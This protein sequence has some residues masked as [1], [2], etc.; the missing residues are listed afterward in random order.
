MK[1]N[2][3]LLFV[4]TTMFSLTSIAQYNHDN[5]KIKANSNS[6]AGN[7]PDNFDVGYKYKNLQLFPVVANKTFVDYNKDLGKF[8]LLKEAITGGKI[9]ITET[10]AGQSNQSG[11]NQNNVNIQQSNSLNLG[12]DVSGTV[13]TLIAKNVSSD[14]IFI[15]AGEVVKG[16]KQDRVIGQDVVIAPGQEVNLSAFCVENNRWQTVDGNNGQ[17]NGY[18]NVSSMDIRKIVTEDKNQSEVWQKVDEHTSKNGASSSTKTYTNLANSEEY[19]KELNAYLEKFKSSFEND[20]SV[21]GVIA[22]SGDKVIGCDLFATNQLFKDAYST[23]VYSYIGHAITNGSPVT[24]TNEMVYT[25]LDEILK[26]EEN[27]IENVEKNG[28]IYEYKK[29]KLHMTKY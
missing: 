13:N 23:L 15:M 29:K 9:V 1:R 25:Y 22:V 20:S 18:F 21:I 2:H 24:I 19:Q 7:S 4:I 11:I 28:T 3:I 26:S 6:N 17:F 14:T 27:Q 12:G 16:G 8:T 10:G 5:L